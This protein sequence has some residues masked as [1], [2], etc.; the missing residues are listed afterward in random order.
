M[1]STASPCRRRQTLAARPEEPDLDAIELLEEL[2][3]RGA[4][5]EAARQHRVLGLVQ[6]LHREPQPQHVHRVELEALVLI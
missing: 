6:G 2:L 5:H 4:A 1:G 3:E